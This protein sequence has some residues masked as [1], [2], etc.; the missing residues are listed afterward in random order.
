MRNSSRTWLDREN[1]AFAASVS[2]GSLVLDAGAG[3]QPYKKHF[4]HC[5]YETA[6][7]EMVDKPYAK[8]TYV[9]DLAS[10]PVEADRFDAVVFNQVLEHIPE[11]MVVLR[12]LNRVMKSGGT[13]IC[14]A[15]FFYEEHEKPYDYFRYTQFAWRRMLTDAGFS[16]QSLNWMEGYFGT[17][18]YQLQIAARSLPRAPAKIAAGLPGWL[19]APVFIVLRPSFRLLAT[20]FSWLD[21]QRRFTEAGMPKNYV[22]IAAK[23]VSA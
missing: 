20:M 8:S 15:P 18:S 7:F 22:V 23:T 14:T 10:I 3:M 6:D 2:A 17:L 16:I 11:P 12:E 5:S 13:I 21:E 1:A 9:C 4:A 19:L